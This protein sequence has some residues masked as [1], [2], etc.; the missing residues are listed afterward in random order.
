MHLFF[1]AKYVKEG[2]CP[3]APVH[4]G[5]KGGEFDN[6]HARVFPPE[7]L[8]PRDYGRG[9][10]KVAFVEHQDER[11]FQ[12][13]HDMVVQRGRKVQRRVADIHNQEEYV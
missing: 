8:L 3:R 9:G 13:R 1:C 5:F 10:D 6:M 12:H 2:C 7:M 11:L 4:R